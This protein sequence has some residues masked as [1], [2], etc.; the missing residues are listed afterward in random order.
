MSDCNFRRAGFL[1]SATFRSA[2]E[3]AGRAIPRSS[4]MA[5]PMPLFPG[6]K[7]LLF[8]GVTLAF[9]AL[10]WIYVRALDRL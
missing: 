9:F 7:D 8:V 4:S 10:G 6:M 5:R 2:V 3:A 1:R